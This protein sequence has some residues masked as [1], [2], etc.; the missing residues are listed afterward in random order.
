[1]RASRCLFQKFS[2]S[3]SPK[4]EIKALVIN[5]PKKYRAYVEFNKYFSG[6]ILESEPARPEDCDADMDP[7]QSD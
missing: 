3:D 5:T 7:S 2:F 1:M 4:K 6:S